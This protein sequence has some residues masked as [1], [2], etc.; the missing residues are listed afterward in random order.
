MACVRG[1]LTGFDPAYKQVT[2]LPADHDTR[3]RK[4]NKGK[5]EEKAKGLI[6]PA[7]IRNWVGDCLVLKYQEG[8]LTVPVPPELLPDNACDKIRHHHLNEI[9]FGY[10]YPPIN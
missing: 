2:R 10:S 6:S 7:K 1:Y 9:Q 3:I 4:T 8:K 5:D